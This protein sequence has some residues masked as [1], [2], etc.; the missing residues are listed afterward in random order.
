[1]TLMRVR[2]AAAAILPIDGFTGQPLKGDSVRIRME[3]KGSSVRKENGFVVFWDNGSRK[4]RLLVESPHFYKEEV[5]LDMDRL[6]QKWQPAYPVWLRP[7]GSY[8]YPSSIPLREG[9]AIP[10][11]LIRLPQEQTSGLIRLLP[12]APGQGALS[13]RLDVP[14]LLYMEGRTLF[15]RSRENGQS[16]YVTIWEERSRS[17]GLYELEMP[18]A[19]EFSFADTEILLVAETF[20]DEKG[21][22]R[23]PEM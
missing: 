2:K 1:M 20:S 17:L 12:P 15:L 9:T 21:Q 4:R 13:L 5:W 10:G 18:P 11:T 7:A 8:P 19:V 22:Y 16:Q 6:G 23:I 14:D 3:D